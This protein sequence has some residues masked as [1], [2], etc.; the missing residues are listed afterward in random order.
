MRTADRTLALGAGIG[1]LTLLSGL[2]GCGRGT[3]PTLPGA[4][5]AATTKLA[6]S[7]LPDPSAHM[8]I[9]LEATSPP[10]LWPGQHKAPCIAT[11][12]TPTRGSVT[13]G[14]VPTSIRWTIYDKCKDTQLIRIDYRGPTNPFLSCPEMPEIALHKAFEVS[15]SGEKPAVDVT[16]TL[17][18]N[19]CNKFYLD[20]NS[21]PDRSKERTDRCEVTSGQIEI[22]PW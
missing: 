10:G 15:W 8:G 6:G 2:P 22:E 13:L 9:W 21:F 12:I 18:P 1:V 11:D 16:C 4:P 5:T 14:G 20:V 7:S 3:S 19:P 17:V